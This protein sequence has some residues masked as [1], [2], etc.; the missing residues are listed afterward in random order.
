MPEF[1]AVPQLRSTTHHPAGRLAEIAAWLAAAQDSEKAQPLTRARA[2]IFSGAHGIAE[3]TV[4]GVGIGPLSSEDEERWR[5]D[6]S[7]AAHRAEAGVEFIECADAASIDVAPAMSAEELERHVELGHKAA[8]REVDSGADF[9]LTSDFGI[10][11]ETVAAAV[12]GR[13]TRTEPVAIL[14]TRTSG[15][16]TDQMWKTR[17]TIVRDAMFRAR[18][19]EGWEVV[20]TI[21]SPSLAA[22]VGFIAQAALRRTPVLIAGP[23]AATAAVLA[24]RSAPGVKGWLRAG[25]TSP[26]PAQALAFKELGLSPLLDLNLSACYPL[27]ALAAL[28]LVQLAAELS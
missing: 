1:T 7:T 12:M 9:L 8:D 3:R 13:I 19:L 21:G 26:E 16:V 10:G 18:N 4:D 22:L 23:L 27:G 11:G 2:I 24:E 17:V 15:G 5:D 28:P 6:I 25:S 20:Q 14:G